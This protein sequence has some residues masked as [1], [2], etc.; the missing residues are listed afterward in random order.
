MQKANLDSN[1]PHRHPTSQ[2]LRCLH[3]ELARGLPPLSSMRHLA[4][5]PGRA[6]LCFVAVKP[7]FL[8]FFTPCLDRSMCRRLSA[9]SIDTVRASKLGE[10]EAVVGRCFGILGKAV[11]SDS[12]GADYVSC[13]LLS[14]TMIIIRVI[15]RVNWVHFKGYQLRISVCMLCCFMLCCSRPLMLSM[16]ATPAS[17]WLTASCPA[18]TPY[19]T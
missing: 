13:H 16:D 12:L 10:M 4:F 8:F 7:F 1:R 11:N 19:C 2:L 5:G 17:A 3:L 18:N 6:V 14:P 9:E 15:G